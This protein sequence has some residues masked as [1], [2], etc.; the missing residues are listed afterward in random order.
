MWIVLLV[1]MLLSSGCAYAINWNDPQAIA[2]RV[3]IEPDEF[4]KVTSFIGP[5]CAADTFAGDMVAIR[6]WKSREG[7][8]EYQVYV[9]DAY[10]YE[11]IRGGSGW[12][13]YTEAYD[14]DG[15]RLTT[16][17][18][19]RTLDW[20]GRNVCAYIESLGIDVTKA[21]LEE[22]SARGMIFKISGTAGE[23]VFSIPPAYVQAFLSVVK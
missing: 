11:I 1:L 9:K 23:E 22:R 15:N 8:L 17:I 18:I 3:R 2:S 13:H 12:R 7:T 6:A 5:N 16:R 4:T 10:T 19:S 21:Y 14:S 20:C